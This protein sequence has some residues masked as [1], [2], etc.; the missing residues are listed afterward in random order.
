MTD[1]RLLV[2]DIGGTNSRFAMAEA[3]ALGFSEQRT[4]ACADFESAELAIRAYLDDVGVS[5]PDSICLA[6]AGPVVNNSVRFTNNHWSIQGDTLSREFGGAPTALINDFEAVAWAIPCLGPEDSVSVGLPESDWLGDRNFT[7][8]IVGPG[9]GLG[10]S[11]VTRQHGVVV[12]LCGD[13]GHQGFAP[14]SQVQTDLLQILRERF[15]RVSYE[16][17]VSGPGLE[18]TYQ[19][20]SMLHGERPTHRDAA[21]IFRRCESGEGPRAEEAVA[22]FF[23]ILGQFAGNLALTISAHDG[24]YLAGGIVKRYP[25]LL[26]NSRFRSGFENKGRYRSLMEVMP[27]RLITHDDPGL[28]GASYY[29]THQMPGDAP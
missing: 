1:G 16:R 10:I 28:L 12:P 13:G 14:E 27:T 23:E 7:V 21:E 22:L 29:V 6:A 4:Y 2:G 15:D 5:G 26:E 17:L 25:H 19:A 9:T 20:L 18:N 11:L 3:G 8:G 24:V